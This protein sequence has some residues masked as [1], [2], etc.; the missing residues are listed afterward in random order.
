MVTNRRGESTTAV[1]GRTSNWSEGSWIPHL[2]RAMTAMII[3]VAA[4]TWTGGGSAS[5]ASPRT[6]CGSAS[7]GST[8]LSLRVNGYTRTVTV[9]VPTGSTNLTPMALILNLHGS[10]GSAATEV[11]FTKM[12]A[13]SDAKRFIVAYPQAYITAGPGFQWN[14]PPLYGGQIVPP[15]SPDDAKFLISLVKILERHYCINPKEVYATGH[16]GGAREVSLLGCV[17]S[18]VFAA[19]APVDGVRRPLPCN[20]RRA[21]SVIAF[22]GSADPVNP[23]DGNGQ[24]YWTYSVL[25]AMQYWGHQ[26]R[27][28]HSST[29]SPG[30]PTV[31]LVTYGGCANGAVVELYEVIG[32]GHDWPGGPTAPPILVQGSPQAIAINANLLMWSFFKAHP[33]A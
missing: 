18:K 2:L 28:T 25:T 27:C 3:L 12:D 11:A 10:S 17:A 1:S 4:L 26:D 6:G 9:H 32:E 31:V 8:T 23:F 19:I 13:T 16:S 22:H 20:T 30:D 7:P 5:F 15:N 21:V 29:T 14:D 24:P 33:L